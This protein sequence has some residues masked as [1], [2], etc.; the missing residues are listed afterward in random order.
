M[1]KQ[2]ERRVGK[3]GVKGFVGVAA[4]ALLVG[5]CGSGAGG[6]G[7]AS[8]KWQAKDAC[9]MLDRA[10]VAAAIGQPITK[11]VPGDL[12]DTDNAT[13]DTCAWWYS[14]AGA[15]TLLLRTSKSATM[16]D[17]DI[18]QARSGGGITPP[19]TDVPGLGHAALW[20]KDMHSLQVFVDG[21]HY[22]TTAITRPPA[23]L[24]TKAAEIKLAKAML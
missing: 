12:S 3:R 22:F 17:G 2:G 24:D 13:I 9:A 21:T 18:A 16:S 8:S 6:G 11:V 23:G 19:W 4:A 14:D 1:G 7:L 5:G 10:G 15:V 20:Q